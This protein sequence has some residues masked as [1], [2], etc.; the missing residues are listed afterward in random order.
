MKE[1]S[2]KSDIV[3]SGWGLRDWDL[4]LKHKKAILENLKKGINGFISIKDSFKKDYEE[5][6]A[7]GL[8]TTEQSET[9]RRLENDLN[10][11]TLELVNNILCENKHS[12]IRTTP[13]TIDCKES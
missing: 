5:C 7:K 1:E 13:R 6:I 11:K 9:L 4:V 3:I 12:H 8:K 2:N 10:N